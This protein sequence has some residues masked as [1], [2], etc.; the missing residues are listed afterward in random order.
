LKI[1]FPRNVFT[2][3]KEILMSKRITLTGLTCIFVSTGI[4]LAMV[5]SSDK[6]TWPSSWPKEL[7]RY[8]NQSKSFDVAHGIQEN[9]HEISFTKRGEFEKAWPHILN[10]KSKGAPLIIERSPSTY[11]VSGSTAHTGV[12]ILCPSGSG[13]EVDGKMY[14]AD[15][16]WPDYLKSP[17]GELP[18]YVIFDH[19]NAKWLPADKTERVG[20]MNRARVDIV[21]I[22]DGKVIDLNRIQLPSNTPIIDNRFKKGIAEPNIGQ[23]SSEAAPSASPGEPSM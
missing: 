9:V 21:L 20:F 6:G 22:T 2:A 10:L 8:R 12:R 15:A 11:G 5:M 3:N 16:P 18:E 14:I 19:D 23:V 1:V 7:E 17:S 4:C 13:S